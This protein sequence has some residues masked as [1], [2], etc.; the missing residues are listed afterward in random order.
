MPMALSFEELIPE[1]HL[2]SHIYSI[3]IRTSLVISILLVALS[4]PFFGMSN[5]A[6]VCLMK[7][8]K[9][10]QILYLQFIFNYVWKLCYVALY[11]FMP[12]LSSIA[13]RSGDG[14]NW[15]FAYH[16]SCKFFSLN[17]S[18][19]LSF[20]FQICANN[21]LWQ[22]LILPCICFLSILRGKVT[23]IQVKKTS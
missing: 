9:P 15:V 21:I 17:I 3:A 5:I 11:D 8:F 23:C 1:I 6:I 14:T 10:A 22:T 12:S 20:N 18:P 7:C 16:A 19:W 13:C 4:V 2:K